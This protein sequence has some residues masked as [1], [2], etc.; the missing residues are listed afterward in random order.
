MVDT[1]KIYLNYNTNTAKIFCFEDHTFIQVLM[2][3]IVLPWIFSSA[4]AIAPVLIV[5]FFFFTFLH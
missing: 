5:Y 3:L 1:W 4:N 2:Y